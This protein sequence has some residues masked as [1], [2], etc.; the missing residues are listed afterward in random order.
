MK[1]ISMKWRKQHK[2]KIS[3]K[4]SF[5]QQNLSEKLSDRP[6]LSE[7]KKE[8]I[9]LDSA[10]AA[11]RDLEKRLSMRPDMKHLE[12][13]GILHDASK[14]PMVEQRRREVEKSQLESALSSRIVNRPSEEVLIKRGILHPR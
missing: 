2:R 10:S 14:S 5:L 11:A 3:A 1:H 13:Q 9:V 4:M 7:L 6:S 8:G 12:N